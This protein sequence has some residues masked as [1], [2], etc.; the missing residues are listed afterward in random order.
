MFLLRRD[1]VDSGRCQAIRRAPRDR[2]ET[3]PQLLGP[4]ELA[5]PMGNE[6]LTPPNQLSLV[7]IW[8]EMAMLVS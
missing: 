7:M 2:R 1:H 3:P 4:F 6:S 8:I 5:E